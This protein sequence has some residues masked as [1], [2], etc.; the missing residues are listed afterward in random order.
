MRIIRT[1]RHGAWR[2]STTGHAA[3][4]TGRTSAP[5][6]GYSLIE[7][8]MVMVILGILAAAV[9]LVISGLSTEAAETGCSADRHVLE[10]A[11]GAHEADTQQRTIAPSGTDHDRYERALVEGGFLR[12]VSTMHDLDANGVVAP[13]VGSG[14]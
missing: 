9:M 6:G 10:V 1:D 3:H 13:E 5:D 11:V 7:V 4:A 14:C 2:R 8:F 12:S